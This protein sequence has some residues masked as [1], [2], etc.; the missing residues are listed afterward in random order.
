MSLLWLVRISTVIIAVASGITESPW[1]KIEM[2]FHPDKSIILETSHSF[3][4]TSGTYTLYI[5]PA[6]VLALAFV[7]V[8]RWRFGSR[9]LSLC[10][11]VMGLGLLTRLEEPVVWQENLSTWT[12]L[13]TTA[14]IIYHS[15]PPLLLAAM[16]LH[17]FI[18][19]E[20]T[21]PQNARRNA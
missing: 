7:A 13:H 2:F 10:Y 9:A 18:E 15:L 8:P 6:L 17:P 4:I 3:L 21:L 19:R 11:F 1:D 20:L 16:L 14:G 5:T 12:R